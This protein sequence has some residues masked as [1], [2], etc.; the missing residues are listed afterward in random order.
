MPVR[1]GTN[2]ASISAQ[3]Q[4]QS[5]TDKRL[6]AIKSLASG[7]RIVQASDDAAGFAIS[8]NL[9]AQLR[10]IQVSQRNAQD[11][12]SFVQVAEGALNEQNNILIRLRELSIQSASDTVSDNER[13]FLDKEFQQL[14][15]EL[16]RIA[17]TTTFGKNKLLVGNDQD[18]EFQ[19][20]PN[21]GSENR[22]SYRLSADSRASTLDID[23][24]SID[25]DDDALDSLDSIDSA[26][27]QIAGMR[28]E[29]GAIQS[30]L[31]TAANHMGVQGENIAGAYS[32]I[33]DADIAKE[34]ANLAQANILSE[35]GISV[36]AQANQSPILAQRLLSS[37]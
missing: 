30:R 21:K 34:T 7:K 27:E 3:N 18:F 32:N 19:V 17:E 16:D 13:E 29:F 23:N 1:I 31:Q 15:S 5:N 28:A 9:R 11:A 6:H 33:A 35:I 4:L 24:L 14:K 8:E 20:G 10:G 2:I 12:V 25:D 22:I 37:F 26:L 36:L